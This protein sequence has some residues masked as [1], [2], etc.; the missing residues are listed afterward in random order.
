MAT[1]PSPVHGLKPLPNF[2]ALDG[3]HCISGSL[4]RIF[5]WADHPLSEEMILGL[6]A[7]LGFLYWRMKTGSGEY[8][9]VG[10]RGNFKGFYEDLAKRTGV[11]IREVR[12]ASAKKAEADLIRDLKENKPVML[13]GDMGMLPWF[14]FPREYHFGAHTFVACGYDGEDTVLCSD[15]DQKGAGVKKGFLATAS[16]AQLRQ[17]RASRF[18]PFPPKNLRLEFDFTHFRKPGKAEIDAAIRQTLDAELHPPIRNCGVKGIRHTAEELLKWPS[19]LNHADLRANLFNLYIF[20]ESGGTGGGCF[21]PM[22]GRF[23]RESAG[24][25]GNRALLKS[26]DEFEEIGQRFSAVGMLFKNAAKVH[27]LEP[28]IE[29]ASKGF[30]E[31]AYLEEQACEHLERSI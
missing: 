13:G 29:A 3:C 4:A 5:Q 1:R 20:I 2:S 16:L 6:G 8:I 12:T 26:A 23:L 25:M 24:I 31:I 27:D 21:R 28:R 11:A 7:G 10:G 14:A 9:F 22:F 17:A 15:I 19:Q 30:R 18:K